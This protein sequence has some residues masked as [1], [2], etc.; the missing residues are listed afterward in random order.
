[1]SPTVIQMDPADRRWLAFLES[2]PEAG[3]FHHPAWLSVLAECYGFPC[4]VVAREQGRE[5]V[6]GLPVMEVR[7]SLRGHRLVSLPFTDHCRPLG[8]A[9]WLPGLL[10]AVDRERTVRGVARA[11]IAWLLDER[12][13]LYRGSPLWLHETPL[14]ADISGLEARLHRTRVRQPV[15]HARRAGVTVA[16]AATPEALE[17]FYDLHL[18]TRQRQGVP[19]QPRRFFRLVAERL[20]AREYGFVSIASYNGSPVAGALFLAWNGRIVFKFGAS[21]PKHWDVSPNHAL[22]WDA[23]VWGVRNGFRVFDW[24]KT[25][26]DQESLREFKRAWGTI[27]RETALMV[28]SDHHPGSHE[29]GLF[30]RVAGGIVRHSPRWVCRSVGE[31]FYGRLA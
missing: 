17:T 28:M 3:I 6:A 19:V 23:M 1:M 24:G 13:G 20:L 7:G 30:H 5:I 15:E 2:R 21:Q 14:D 10:D 9:V 22:L 31:I 25:G 18:A 12:P 16:R 27:E 4:F 8:D 26:R 29:S 11:E